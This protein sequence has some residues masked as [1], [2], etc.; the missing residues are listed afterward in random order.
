VRLAAVHHIVAVAGG[1]KKRGGGKL[2][3][4]DFLP[5]E[6]EHDTEETLKKKLMAMAKQTGTYH[7]K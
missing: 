5:Q 2:Q 4:K 6:D 1:M 3:F 7:G